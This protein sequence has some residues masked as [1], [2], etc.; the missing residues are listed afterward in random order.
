MKKILFLIFLLPL[1]TRGQETVLETDSVIYIQYDTIIGKDTVWVFPYY[2]DNIHYQSL[3]IDSTIPDGQ[4]NAYLNDSVTLLLKVRY[5]NYRP[6]GIVYYYQEGKIR[7]TYSYKN[8]EWDG[9]Y[10]Y[11]NEAG[12]LEAIGSKKNGKNH[13]DS[14]EYWSNGQLKRFEHSE[15]GTATGP[16]KNY[17][18]NGQINTEGS[19]DKAGEDLGYWTGYRIGKWTEYYENG[20]IKEEQYYIDSIGTKEKLRIAEYRKAKN[21]RPEF[22]IGSAVTYDKSGKKTSEY[23]YKDYLL[24]KFVKYYSNGKE[25]EITNYTDFHQGF[26]SQ[27]PSYYIKGG[28]YY[29]YYESGNKKVE[30]NYLNNE[31]DGEWHTWS[32]NGQLIKK[33]KYKN[34]KLKR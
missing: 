10:T 29:E 25:K 7:S 34:G 23:I 19:Y 20:K 8:G 12:E 2:F 22:P 26:C 21:A 13:G 30:G 17:Y 1:I 15:M 27:N 18:S 4:Y 3:D 6:E 11:Y 31:K 32:E 9:P 14:Y 24:V 33:E 16:Y 28:Q 5:Q